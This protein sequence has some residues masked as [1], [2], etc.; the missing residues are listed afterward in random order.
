[1]Q[2]KLSHQIVLAIMK[3]SIIPALLLMLAMCSYANDSAGQLF[4]E[5]KITLRAEQV[6]IKNV[7]AGIERITKIHFV[8]SPELIDASMKVS[9]NA[10]K[11]EVSAILARLLPPL[12][13]EYE[14]ISNYIVLRKK[15]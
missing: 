7:L 11:K 4:L 8:Y 2:K 6:E 12:H 13:I 10:H 15:E 9:I 3:I 1:M 5:K 14:V